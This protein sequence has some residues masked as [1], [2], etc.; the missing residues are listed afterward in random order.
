MDRNKLIKRCQELRSMGSFAYFISE[1]ALVADPTNL[2]TLVAAFPRLL[3]PDYP[4]YGSEDW[5]KSVKVLNNSFPFKKEER[6]G[7]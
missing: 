2:A 7:K 1:A 6:C 5:W 3:D 4:Q